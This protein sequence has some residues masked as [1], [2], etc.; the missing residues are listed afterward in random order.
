VDIKANDIKNLR[1][2]TG[3]GMMDCKKALVEANG[4]IVGAEKILREWGMA[5]V[6][7]R[8]GRATNEGRVFIKEGPGKIS[9]AEIVC[10]TDFVCR[11][12]DFINAGNKVVE[13]AF[14]K[15]YDKPADELEAQIK[16]IAALIKENIAL[17]RVLL[18][19]SGSG[20]YLH[21]YIHGEGSLAVV[22]KMQ[23]DKP[24]AFEN[25]KVKA[26]VHDIALH[27]A[28]FNPMFLDQTKP[29]SSWIQE[30]K[31]IFQKQVELDEK[32]KSKPDKV[33]QGIL[34]G[35]LKKL[36]S[37]ISLLDQ[38]FVKEEKTPVA[39]AMATIAKEA[40]CKLEIVDYAYVKVGEA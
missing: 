22:V 1:E 10:E 32:M 35:K 4:N 27:I 8:A 29:S 14:I 31:D 13:T 15:G 36:M 37:E 12:K 28:A 30:Q 18:M 38:G 17:K 9:V 16:D 23:S 33:I 40:G 25:E 7:K 20:E 26:F 6:E 19:T 3:A 2:K 39:Q 5:G 21:S 11:N 24:E 34:A